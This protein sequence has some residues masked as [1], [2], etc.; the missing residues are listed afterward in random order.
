M[1]AEVRCSVCG[2]R[3]T[4][5]KWMDRGIGPTCWAALKRK[6]YLKPLNVN[7]LC[8]RGWAWLIGDCSCAPDEGD[9]N[10][11]AEPLAPIMK[12]ASP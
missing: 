3:L 8:P 2:R 4:I 9:C 7:D 5:Q 1:T 11:C 12:E 6:E 10:D